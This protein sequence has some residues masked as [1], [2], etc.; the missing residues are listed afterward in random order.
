MGRYQK[1]YYAQRSHLTKAEKET[2]AQTEEMVTVGRED[3]DLSLIHIFVGDNV[4][5]GERWG[6]FLLIVLET[7]AW[8]TVVEMCIRDRLNG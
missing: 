3:L 8:F 1:P 6:I 7:L 5:T 4:G 2:R